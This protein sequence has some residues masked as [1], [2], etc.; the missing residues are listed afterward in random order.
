[1]KKSNPSTTVQASV[2]GI[3]DDDIRSYAQH[4]YEQ[5]GRI[6]DRDLDNWLEAKACLEAGVGVNESHLRLHT[7]L[8]GAG[9]KPASRVRIHR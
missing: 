5:S 4:L 7:F 6:N 9:A 2:P 1:M 8:N 3:T